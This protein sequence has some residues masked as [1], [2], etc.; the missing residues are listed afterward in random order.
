MQVNLPNAAMKSKIM[1]CS[2]LQNKLFLLFQAA[3]LTAS[4]SSGCFAFGKTLNMRLR[5]AASGETAPAARNC[6]EA[7]L[8]DVEAQQLCVPDVSSRGKTTVVFVAATFPLLL[9]CLHVPT[10]SH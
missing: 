6:E 4:I 9:H 10:V 7:R 1:K 2:V 8:Q 5:I 3:R